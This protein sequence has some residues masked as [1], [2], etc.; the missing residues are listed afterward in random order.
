MAHFKHRPV[1]IVPANVHKTFVDLMLRQGYKI[2]L[3]PVTSKTGSTITHYI[4][5]QQMDD[6][7]VAAVNLVFKKIK[8]KNSTAKLIMENE[9][10]LTTTST[11]RKRDIKTSILNANNLKMQKS[12]DR[13]R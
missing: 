4:L 12:I 1:I 9:K 5:E 2:V 13:R 10:K 7:M 11:A 6:G 8:E 3:H